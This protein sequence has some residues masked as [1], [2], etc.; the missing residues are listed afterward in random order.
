MSFCGFQRCVLTFGL[1]EGYL[2][3]FVCCEVDFCELFL[4]VCRFGLLMLCFV[5]GCACGFV[6]CF[7]VLGE[8]VAFGFEVF[9]GHVGFLVFGLLVGMVLVLLGLGVFACGFL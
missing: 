1:L 8:L 9:V 3:A 4:C 2:S 7:G 5:G 6:G